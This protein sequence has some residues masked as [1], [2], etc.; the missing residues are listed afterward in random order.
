MITKKKW[1]LILLPIIIGLVIISYVL[2]VMPIKKENNVGNANAIIVSNSLG[3]TDDTGG[4][5]CKFRCVKDGTNSWNGHCG[6]GCSCPAG[7]TCKNIWGSIK[8]TS[9]E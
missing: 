4:N 2:F 1:L 6:V 9:V 5:K 8:P 3:N 7:Y